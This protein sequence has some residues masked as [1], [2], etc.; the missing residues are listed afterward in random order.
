MN[1]KNTIGLGPLTVPCRWAPQSLAT[2][3]NRTCLISLQTAVGNILFNDA[4]NTF[5]LP[6]IA[7]DHSDSERGNPLPLNRHK[8]GF[9]YMHHQMD[10]I[11]HTTV[12]VI[13]S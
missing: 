1:P 13:Q 5:Y 6:C 8:Q 4:I 7:S 12:F 11:I 10:R 2:P 3:V 9:F